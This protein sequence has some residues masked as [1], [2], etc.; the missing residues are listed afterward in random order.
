MKELTYW[1]GFLIG[2]GACAFHVLFTIFCS[3]WIKKRNQKKYE[4]LADE[5]KEVAKG[6]KNGRI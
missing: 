4:N 5:F 1:I 3:E 2:Y 6:E